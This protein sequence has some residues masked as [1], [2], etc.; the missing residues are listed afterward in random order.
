MIFWDS[1]TSWYGLS[2]AKS[3]INAING[4]SVLLLLLNG[5]RYWPLCL[6]FSAYRCQRT[7]GLESKKFKDNI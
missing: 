2:C 7:F 1:T 6:C 3:A 4:R 5:W